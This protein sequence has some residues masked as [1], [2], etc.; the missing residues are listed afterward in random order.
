MRPCLRRFGLEDLRP[1]SCSRHPCP[2]PPSC[3]NRVLPSMQ[4]LLPLAQVPSRIQ[5]PHSLNLC[6][7]QRQLSS[8]HP[9]V[10]LSKPFLR[11]RE[12]LILGCVSEYSS[13]TL[14]SP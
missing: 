1:Q 4:L 2:R 13:A 12:L 9:L 8:L 7:A 10:D 6:V 14:Q 11:S 5:P 3:G